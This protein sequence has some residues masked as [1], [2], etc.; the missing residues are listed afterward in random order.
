MRSFKLITAISC[1]LIGGSPFASAAIKAPAAPSNLAV[2]A[3]GVNAFQVSWKDNSKN[4]TGWEIRVSLKGG[5]PQRFVLVPT[6][7]IT[8]YTVMTNE[9]AGKELVFQ[10]TAYNGVAGQENLSKLTPTVTVRALS[11]NKFDKPTMLQAK[12]IDD[13]RIQLTWVDNATS[14]GGYQIETRLGTKK[15]EVLGG[16]G[17]GIKFKIITSGY[18]P[19]ET[20]SFRVRAFKADKFTPYSNVA[21]ATTKAFRAPSSL[22]VTA[23]R[24][25][26]FSFKWNDRSAVESG[27]EI[28]SKVGSGSFQSLGTVAANAT[29]TGSVSGF[30]PSSSHQFRVRAFR[31]VGTVR[32]YSGFSNV[33][34]IQSTPLAPPATLAGSPAS[35]SSATLTWVDKSARETG[36][37]IL[38][39]VVGTTPFASAFAAANA[40]TFTVG[41]LASATTYEFRVSAVVNGFFGNRVASSSYKSV[42]VRTQEGFVGSFNPPILAGSSFLYPLQ[43]SLPSAL[44]GLTVTGLPAGLTFNSSNGTITGILTTAGAYTATLTATF[45]DGST[46]TRSL[47]LKSISPSPAVVQ[48]FAAVSVPIATPKTVSVAGK[49]S[50]PDTAS[51][52]RVTTTL[53]TFDIILFPYSAPQTV[54]NFLDY[55]DAGEYD[56]VFFHRSPPDF[57]VQGGGYKY[58]AASG[59]TTVN[60]FVRVLP[61]EPGLSNVRGTVAMAKMGGQPDSAT[62]EFFINRRN[63]AANLD[64]QNGG[65]TVFGRVPDAGMVVVDQINALPVYNYEIT[66]G[67]ETMALTDV[68]VNAASAPETLD[69]TQLVKITS[70]DAAPILTYEVL[71]QNTAVATASL[72]GTDIT[73]TAV[74]TGNTTIEVKAIDLDGNTVTQNIAVTVP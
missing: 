72:T 66:V 10:M 42:Q 44:T 57:V 46:A 62:S 55:T 30:T 15:W 67:T 65:F 16:L 33:I 61:N 45:G 36:Y 12:A 73:I 38:Y 7:N 19:S 26:A 49:F 3:L 5:T 29:T 59:F 74:A 13:G 41:N 39:R 35:D 4:E 56:N 63:N 21:T 11:P 8:T 34:S 54:D 22:V 69:P 23:L 53:G 37:E 47:I 14:E 6:P 17:A 43:V 9:L 60:K 68:P 2:K 1:F 64:V 58:T 71:S 50:D 27:F 48:S 32:T 52:A 24:E 28:E 51:A 25:G 31:L 40:Q 70:V 20:R 18:L